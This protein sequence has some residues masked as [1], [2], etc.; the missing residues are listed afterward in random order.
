MQKNT[1]YS[2][3]WCVLRTSYSPPPRPSTRGLP[4]GEFQWTVRTSAADLLRDLLPQL[5]QP[6]AHGLIANVGAVERAA[7]PRTLA[8][9]TRHEPECTY[10]GTG[11]KGCRG[12]DP[13]RNVSTTGMD[14]RRSE[15]TRADSLLPKKPPAVRDSPEKG[16]PSRTCI[17]AV[18]HFQILSPRPICCRGF[19][20]F[21]SRAAAFV[22]ERHIALIDHQL[23]HQRPQAAR[24]GRRTGKR[25]VSDGMQW[26]GARTPLKWCPPSLVV[27]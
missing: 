12:P 13:S 2:F 15:M 9:A 4:T 22:F 14:F 18:L 5:A 26:H 11:V 7:E 16:A 20:G 8:R 21:F 25:A 17:T 24:G 1:R 23:A 10:L 27:S 19:A 3:R 6:L